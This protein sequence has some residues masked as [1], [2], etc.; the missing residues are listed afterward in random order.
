MYKN[1]YINSK[2]NDLALRSARI[3]T[4]M[5]VDGCRISKCCRCSIVDGNMEPCL[6]TQ[7]QQVMAEICVAMSN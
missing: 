2:S 6:L 4:T 5:H 3:A 7:K 1:P